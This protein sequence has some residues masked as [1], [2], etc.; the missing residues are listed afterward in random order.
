[1]IVARP[2]EL[3]ALSDA[4]YAGTIG[5]A[6]L[7]VYEIE[8]LPADHRLWK[9]P[10]VLLTPHMAAAG[11]YLDE[12]RQ[13]LLDHMSSRGMIGGE[14][15]R[16]D[17][18]GHTWDKVS[19]DGQSIGGAPAYYYGQIIIDPNDPDVVH[20]LSAASWGTN[21]KHFGVVGQTN[22]PAKPIH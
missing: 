21:G 14:V 10:N 22:R 11:P 15:Y 8:P 19:P 4:L 16:S 3:D 18:A 5:G 6:A 9:A 1:M 20:V 13:E 7:D 12:R 17:D 2:C